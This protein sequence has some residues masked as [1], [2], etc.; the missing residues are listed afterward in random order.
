MG[1]AS[2]PTATPPITGNIYEKVDGVGSWGGWCACPDGQRYSVG[3][4]WDA[5]ANGPNSLA[6]EGG[7]PGEC[8]KIHD[9]SREGMR[10]TCAAADPMDASLPI[11]APSI[12]GNI[13]E[14]IEG[15]G[16]WGG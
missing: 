13:Y 7:V 14:K 10:V 3:D 16:S 6:C 4:R 9:V 12:T 11:P 15:V 2:S 1:D 5:C 8:E